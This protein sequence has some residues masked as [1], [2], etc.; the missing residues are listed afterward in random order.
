MAD[1][2]VFFVSKQLSG[3]LLHPMK[4]FASILASIVLFLSFIPCADHEFGQRNGKAKAELVKNNKGGNEKCNDSCSP[5]C[6]CSCCAS[7]S[8]DHPV[9]ETVSMIR[10]PDAH[11]PSRNIA[12]IMEV[13]LPIW[14]PPQLS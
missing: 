9:I 5:F 1:L 6:H 10:Q 2:S 7:F 11:N 8:Y 13:S 14:Q 3:L 12:I 4:I